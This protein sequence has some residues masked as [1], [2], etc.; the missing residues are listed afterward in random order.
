MIYEVIK[1]SCILIGSFFGVSS[2]SVS[3]VD[4]SLGSEVVCLYVAVGWL[5]QSWRRKQRKPQL[6]YLRLTWNSCCWLHLYVENAS[7]ASIQDSTMD[8]NLL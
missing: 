5:G 6:Q 3:L 4:W 1:P 2:V 8:A 7:L